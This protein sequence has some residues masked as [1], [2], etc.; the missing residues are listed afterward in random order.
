MN[1]A[2]NVGRDFL[3]LI[4]MHFPPDHILHSV[5][6]R[7]TV[8]VSYRCL[9]SMGAEISK[10]NNKI[11]KNSQKK[12]SRKKPSCNC[13]KSKVS[14]CPL[15]GQCNTNGVVYQ[16][17]VTNNTGAKETYIGLAKNFKKKYRQHKKSMIDRREEGA[18]TLSTH[19]WQQ[20]DEWYAYL[21][22]INSTCSNCIMN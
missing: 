16:A 12:E 3:R 18:T 14:E 7:S 2:T 6:N 1:V 4:D 10:H 22:N 13:Q 8:K 11:L 19:F 17:T 20:K 15:P 21:I 5:I 9:P